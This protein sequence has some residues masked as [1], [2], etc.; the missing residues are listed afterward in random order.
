VKELTHDSRADEELPTVRL[1]G[2]PMSDG[3]NNRDAP[4]TAEVVNFDEAML[5]ACAP[6]LR[7]DLLAEAAMLADAFAPEGEPEHLTAMAHALSAGERDSE[8]DRNHARRLAAAL[9][10]LAQ[11]SEG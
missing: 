3:S 4:P 6:D 7:A 1:V 9:R 5:D 11:R 8:M 10:H 2:V